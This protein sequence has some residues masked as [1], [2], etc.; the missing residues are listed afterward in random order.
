MQILTSLSNPS[1]KWC[2]HI[3]GANV[4][5]SQIAFPLEKLSERNVCPLYSLMDAA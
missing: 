5:D 3:T 1:T 2:G 4:H